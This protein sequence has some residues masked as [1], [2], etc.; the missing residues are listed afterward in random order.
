MLL[1]Y[2]TIWSGELQ[3]RYM[4]C[5]VAILSQYMSLGLQYMI[6]HT[7]SNA[8]DNLVLDKAHRVIG[9]R[10]CLQ[11]EHVICLLL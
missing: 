4:Q 5:S 6:Q 9:L 8:N 2:R 7:H 10:V 3:I 1:A 11:K